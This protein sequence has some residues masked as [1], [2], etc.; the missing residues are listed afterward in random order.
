M[1][2]NVTST[3]NDTHEGDMEWHDGDSL[4]NKLS[5]PAKDVHLSTVSPLTIN[6]I[7]DK[8][9]CHLH[10]LNAELLPLETIL[11]E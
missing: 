7:W 1:A 2:S 11:L 3:E 9:E 5:V 4:Y 6:D 10:T 8:A